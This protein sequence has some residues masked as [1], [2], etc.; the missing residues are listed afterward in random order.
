MDKISCVHLATFRVGVVGPWNCNF[1]YAQAYPEVAAKLAVA[2][3]NK[4]STVN[5]VY[6]FD[7]VLLNEECQ[8]S[9]ALL[10]FVNLERY[11]SGFIGPVNPAICEAAGWLGRAWNKAIFSW[12]CLS[13]DAAVERYGTFARALPQSAAVIYTVLQHFQWA[14]V[15]IITSEQHLWVEVGEALAYALRNFGLPV[16]V[17]TTMENEPDGAKNALCKIQNADNIRVIV[18][19]MHSALLGGQEETHLLEKAEE[20]DMIDGTYVF[21]PYDAL[22]YSMPYQQETYTILSENSKLRRAYD[23]V[24]TLTIDSPEV[25]FR[26]AFREAQEKREIPVHINADQVHPLFGTIFNSIYFLAKAVDNTQK[27]GK[28]VMGSTVSKY[29][30]DFELQGFSQTLAADEYGEAVLPYIILD[31]DGKGNRLWPTYSVDVAAGTLR[32]SGHTVH[33]PHSSMPDEDSSCWF[34]SSYICSGGLDASYIVLLFVLVGLLVMLGVCLA[35][36]IRRYIQHA[37]LMKGPNKMILTMDDLT[38]INTQSSKKKMDD[39]HSSVGGKSTV[40]LKSVKSI[41]ANAENS[42]VAVME[43]EEKQ[44]ATS[45][46]PLLLLLFNSQGIVAAV[47]RVTGCGLEE[48][49]GDTNTPEIRPATTKTV[50]ASSRIYFFDTKTLNLFS[51]ASLS[52]AGIFA[53][54]SRALFSLLQESPRRL[55]SLLEDMKLDWNVS[56]VI[57]AKLDLVKGMKYLHHRE[58]LSHGG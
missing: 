25:S 22:T 13:D 26:Q 7:Y 51:W 44:K 46:V 31:T 58:K 18:M 6:W 24:L 48:I 53:I 30:K 56:R 52:R 4:D 21:L 42:N 43:A 28:W 49:P 12:S 41:A 37:Q 32:H 16:G 9:Q 8:T 19:C 15:A 10:G 11:A 34:D 2:R 5:Q 27:S 54:V 29:T 38:F 1:I 57:F 23:A 47:Q 50:F 17:V 45:Q 20:L 36:Y 3:I 39:S 33:W 40:D 35:L 14:H 55:S